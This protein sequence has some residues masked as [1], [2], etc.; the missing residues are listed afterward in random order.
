MAVNEHREPICNAVSYSWGVLKQLPNLAQYFLHCTVSSSVGSVDMPHQFTIFSCFKVSGIVY[1]LQYGLV[2]SK[3][4]LEEG[5]VIPIVHKEAIE[6][7]QFGIQFSSCN[8]CSS[9]VCV[10][11][12]Y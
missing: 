12:F 1:P 11:Y 10:P 5:M 7:G 6:L 4:G 8:R 9:Y 3:V 2:V